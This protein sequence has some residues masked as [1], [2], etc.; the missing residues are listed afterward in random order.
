M[1]IDEETIEYELCPI[2]K[3]VRMQF[4]DEVYEKNLRYS[5]KLG[6]I[7]VRIFY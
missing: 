5:F 3:K 6:R 1:I 4:G 7:N 2:E